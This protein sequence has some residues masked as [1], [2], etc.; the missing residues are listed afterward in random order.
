MQRLTIDRIRKSMD[1]TKIKLSC[2]EWMDCLNNCGCPMAIFFMANSP[3]PE[4]NESAAEAFCNGYFGEEYVNG[5]VNGFDDPRRD[6]DW[7]KTRIDDT[8]RTLSGF[9]DGI[10]ARNEF[11]PCV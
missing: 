8:E 10:A 9:H 3:Y 6:D 4:P 11:L 5:F 1:E 2:D 7:C